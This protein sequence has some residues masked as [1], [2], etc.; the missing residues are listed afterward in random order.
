MA[1][2]LIETAQKRWRKVNKPHLVRLIREGVPFKDGKSV[3]S[4]TENRSQ[5]LN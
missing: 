1:Y 2:K 3:P 5:P 4:T